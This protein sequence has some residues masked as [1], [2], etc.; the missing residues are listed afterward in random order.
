M[1]EFESTEIDPHF[2]RALKRCFKAADIVGVIETSYNYC[3]IIINGSAGSYAV[4]GSY[5]ETM[6]KI[7]A[8]LE[9]A[10]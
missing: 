1:L 10:S 7:K 2:K 5:S 8:A 6:D 9:R 4:R 3:L